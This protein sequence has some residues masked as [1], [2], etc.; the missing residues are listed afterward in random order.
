MQQPYTKLCFSIASLYLGGV[1][2]SK[3]LLDAKQNKK[4]FQILFPLYLKTQIA[5]S[6]FF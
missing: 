2:M 4:M 5:C 6:L 3:L 1:V